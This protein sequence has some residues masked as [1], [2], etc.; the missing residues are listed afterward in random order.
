[1][2]LSRVFWLPLKF[3]KSHRAGVYIH[4]Y[5]LTNNDTIEII[6]L[7]LWNFYSP[8]IIMTSDADGNRWYPYCPCKVTK[9]NMI[10]IVLGKQ[11]FRISKVEKY[12]FEL[13]RINKFTWNLFFKY[14]LLYILGI[15]GFALVAIVLCFLLDPTSVQTKPGEKNIF[16]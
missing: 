8:T 15:F 16:S 9:K 12:N 10:I 11:F 14:L 3:A 13:Y 4:A 7:Y 1:M 5:F 2:M 6:Y